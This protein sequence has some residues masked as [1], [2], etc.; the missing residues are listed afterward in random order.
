[1]LQYK[2]TQT[3]TL[4]QNKLTH[5]HILFTHLRMPICL[6]G[7]FTWRQ[8]EGVLCLLK[9]IDITDLLVFTIN[10]KP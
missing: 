5:Y 3:S 10:L 1:M 6:Y 4:K 9:L 8:C 2:I 7:V